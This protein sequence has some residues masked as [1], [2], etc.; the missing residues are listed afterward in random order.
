MELRGDLHVHTCRSPDSDTT[1]EQALSAAKSA[2]LD[3][4]ALTDHNLSPDPSLYWGPWHRGRR[5]PRE[6]RT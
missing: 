3:F 6:A 5:S 4:L 2:G 1:L